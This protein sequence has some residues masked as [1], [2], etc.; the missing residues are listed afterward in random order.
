MR[1]KNHN[2]TEE[3]KRLE[4]FASGQQS[5]LGGNPHEFSSWMDGSGLNPLDALRESIQQ[6][7]QPSSR[8]MT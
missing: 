3:Y 7:S 1:E 6:Y 4:K 2:S 5:S 8:S